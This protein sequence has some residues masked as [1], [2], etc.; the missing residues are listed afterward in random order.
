MFAWTPYAIASM[1]VVLF[2]SKIPYGYHEYPS[3]FAKTSN[4][5]NPIIYFFTYQSLREK[6]IDM[7][8]CGGGITKVEPISLA[9][10]PGGA[11]IDS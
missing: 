3:L 7:L 9:I 4:I 10:T 11:K 6:A 8:R 1:L 2:G 5:Y